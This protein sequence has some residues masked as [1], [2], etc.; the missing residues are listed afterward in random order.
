MLLYVVLY[1]FSCTYNTSTAVRYV[2][3]AALR[4]VTQARERPGE[5]CR[6]FFAFLSPPISTTETVTAT[7]KAPDA[8]S[9]PSSIR[10]QPVAAEV[11]NHPPRSYAVAEP[12]NASSGR[13]R[14]VASSSSAT[15]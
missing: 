13:S 2:R 4:C 15:G 3:D 10:S 7:S 11:R 1:S 6:H 9:T 12:R 5:V 8:A 14:N